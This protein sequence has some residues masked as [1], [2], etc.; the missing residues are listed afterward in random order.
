MSAE[1]VG[2][3]RTVEWT[4]P[5]HRGRSEPLRGRAPGSLGR[6][7]RLDRRW[8][9][10]AAAAELIFGAGLLILPALK[11][12]SESISTP[13]LELVAS[14]GTVRRPAWVRQPGMQERRK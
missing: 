2:G 5:R 4:M 10:G 6:L 8:G 9:P 12:K 13:I 3:Q 14:A 1:M 11:D 7:S